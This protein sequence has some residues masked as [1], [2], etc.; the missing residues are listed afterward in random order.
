MN[1]QAVVAAISKFFTAKTDSIEKLKPKPGRR[2]EAGH[3]MDPNW[4]EC[5]Y[6]KAEKNAKMKTVHEAV[7]SPSSDDRRTR[8][9]REPLPDTGRVTRV[10]SGGDPGAA[11]LPRQMD[12][13]KI[14]G[15]LA[16]FTW[17]PSGDVFVVREGK[18]FIGAGTVLS[19]GG[20]RPCDVHIVSDPT[21]SKE[22][23]LILCRAGRFDLV[24]Q[25]SQN[26]TYLN[27]ALVP[28]Q[29]T[30]LPNNSK[31]KVGS[32]ILLF[33]RIDNPDTATPIIGDGP[34]PQRPRD[35]TVV[36]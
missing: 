29:G 25:K 5:P 26:G 34:N 2:C 22:H 11:E 10:E 17:H 6:C 35:P 4:E 19:E 3:L 18:N 30:E 13:R 24:D 14:V 33:L 15:V 7:P 12:T 36:R 31:I 16:T 32:T 23:A 20:H 28:I 8:I 21:L 9:D 1:M 27:D